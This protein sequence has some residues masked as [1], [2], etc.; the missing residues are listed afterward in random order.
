MKTYENFKVTGLRPVWLSENGRLLFEQDGRL[1][2][3]ETEAKK[4][5]E[6]LSAA[7]YTISTICPT[8]DGRTLYY[9]VQKTESDLW[10][11]T[12]E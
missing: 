1:H 10:L 11:L 4:S 2:I 9:T 5:H 8:R 7:P 3:L 12:R 6:I